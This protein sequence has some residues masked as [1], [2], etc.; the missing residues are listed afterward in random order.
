MA[1]APASPAGPGPDA[2]EDTIDLLELGVLLA[3]RKRFIALF[4]FGLAVFTMLLTLMMRPTFTATAVMM[5]PQ[6]SKSP[7]DQLGG[8]AALAGGGGGAAAALG[9]KNPADLYIGLLESES[10]AD[11]LIQRFHLMQVYK[12]KKLSAARK[13]LKGN[14]KIV[15]EKSGLISIAVE[16]HD[17]VRA[18]AIANAYIDGLHELM[19][20][21]AVTEA[22]QRR[23][24]FEEQLEQEKNKLADAEVALEQT[25]QKTGI[26]QPAGQAE[27]AITTI[28][29]MR[30]QIASSQVQL[31][32]LETSATPENPEVV[33]LQ[34]QIAGLESQLADFERGNPG[35]AGALGDVEIPTSKVPAA[36]LEYIRKMRDVRYHETLFEMLARQFEIAKVDEAKAGEIVQVVDPALVPDKKSWPPRALLTILAGFLGVLFASFW[37]ILQAAYQ[38]WMTDPEQSVKLREFKAAMRLRS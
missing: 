19:G 14:T 37:V 28:A 38:N 26:I 15:S 7:L 11:G 5:P 3:R 4:G 30:A 23:L 35:V 12:A 33:R 25:E 2:A 21:L 9:L 29:Q 8:L 27:A 36:S 13:A 18:A 31:Q 16:D 6:Q 1:P 22:G 20:H 10:I 32:A 24:F 34:T 17:P